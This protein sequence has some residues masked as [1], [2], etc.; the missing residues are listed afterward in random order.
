[1]PVTSTCP[2]FHLPHINL[3]NHV[4]QEALH[5]ARNQVPISIGQW[6]LSL[7]VTVLVLMLPCMVYAVAGVRW[8]CHLSWYEELEFGDKRRCVWRDLLIH[9]FWYC[10]LKIVVQLLCNCSILLIFRKNAVPAGLYTTNKTFESLSWL[11]FG[12]DLVMQL[13]TRCF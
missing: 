12:Y 9:N 2:A 6:L 8:Y 7:F 3:S 11:M 1:M 5:D 4:I 10:L 13:L